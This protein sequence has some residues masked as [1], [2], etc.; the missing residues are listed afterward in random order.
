VELVEA[1]VAAVEEDSSGTVSKEWRAEE[2]GKT[3]R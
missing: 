2:K 1:M 3:Y